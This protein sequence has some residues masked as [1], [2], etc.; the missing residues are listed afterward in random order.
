MTIADQVVLVVKAAWEKLINL[1]EFK[2]VHEGILKLQKEEAEEIL[3]DL[4]AAVEAVE[5]GVV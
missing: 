1:K 2:S 3:T 5:V 4:T